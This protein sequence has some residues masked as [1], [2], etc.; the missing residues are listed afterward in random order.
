MHVISFTVSILALKPLHYCILYLQTAMHLP[1]TKSRNRRRQFH[2][3][4]CP[5]PLEWTMLEAHVVFH[6]GFKFDG[7]FSYIVCSAL[8]KKYLV[9]I[10]LFAYLAYVTRL[11]CECESAAAVE[12][13]LNTL[14]SVAGPPLLKHQKKSAKRR[15]A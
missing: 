2:T 13:D 12:Q 6:F 7:I 1:T 8:P 4:F 14:K 9:C 3:G 5:G 11:T 15:S 10:C